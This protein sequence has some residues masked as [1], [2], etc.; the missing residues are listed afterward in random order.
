MRFRLLVLD[1]IAPQ[2]ILCDPAGLLTAMRLRMGLRMGW[3]SGMRSMA[4]A[5]TMVS[6]S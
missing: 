6:I 2:F 4:A 3:S 5:S 1:G